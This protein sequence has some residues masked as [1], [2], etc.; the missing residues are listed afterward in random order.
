MA[1]PARKRRRV[2]DPEGN[3]DWTRE[4]LNILKTLGDKMSLKR[5]AETHFPHLTYNQVKSKVYSYHKKGK[6]KQK[7][8]GRPAAE[9]VA[10]GLSFMK[11]LFP[12][13]AIWLTLPLIEPIFVQN[14]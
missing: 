1:E 2:R 5:L 8:R 14:F 3:H 13:S 9:D 11:F 12:L 6:V 4:E 7:K 10:G